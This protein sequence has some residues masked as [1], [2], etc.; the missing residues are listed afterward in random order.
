VTGFKADG[1]YPAVRAELWYPYA[2]TA[3]DR[4]K[5]ESA[6]AHHLWRV[7]WGDH[8]RSVLYYRIFRRFRWP[9]E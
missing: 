3:P 1:A 9:I 2:E 5:F 4:A 7:F 8:G 6:A